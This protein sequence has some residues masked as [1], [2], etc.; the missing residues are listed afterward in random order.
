MTTSGMAQT[1]NAVRTPTMLIRGDGGDN[2]SCE[3]PD[4]SSARSGYAR[5]PPG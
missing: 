5:H 3:I 1:V 4:N 2:G